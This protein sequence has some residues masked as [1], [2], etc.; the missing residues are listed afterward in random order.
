MQLSRF[1]R[2]SGPQPEKQSLKGFTLIELLVVIAI[3]AILAAILFPVFARA[4]ENA[5][6]ASCQSNLKQIGLGLMQYT[7]DYDES[8]L[9]K[10]GT[11]PGQNNTAWSTTLQ[12]YLKSIQIFRCPSGVE[13][14]NPPSYSDGMWQ[15]NVPAWTARA[16]AHYGINSNFTQTPPTRLAQVDK[17]AETAMAFDCTQMDYSELITS[18]NPILDGSRHFDGINVL[19]ADGHV[20]PY[21]SRQDPYNLRFDVGG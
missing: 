2:R 21:K 5:R 13:R 3:I 14:V 17:P 20:K 9:P 7:Q 19:Y 4:R 12:P 1:Y 10:F 15:V 18:S 11:G 8:Y 16:E 6:R